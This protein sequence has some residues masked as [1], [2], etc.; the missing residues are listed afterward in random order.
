LKHLEHSGRILVEQISA[1]DASDENTLIKF[2][3]PSERGCAEIS[4]KEM[5]LFALDS[6]ISRL[7]QKTNECAEKASREHA[8]A[9]QCLQQKNKQGALLALQRKKM[10]EEECNRQ[11]NMLTNLE[12][13]KFTLQAAEDTSTVFE[14]LSLATATTG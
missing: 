3:G 7:E 2:V 6:N 5:A 10:F 14:T 1:S 12:K 8:K 11:Q 4:R 9:K 13:Q